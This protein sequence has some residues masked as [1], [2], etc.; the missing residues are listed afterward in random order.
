[1]ELPRAEELR[2]A[3]ERSLEFQ[4]YREV[5]VGPRASNAVTVRMIARRRAEP[6]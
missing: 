1:M 6:L 2:M 5:K 3:F 4:F